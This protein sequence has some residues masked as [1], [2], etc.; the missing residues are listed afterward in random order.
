M[1]RSLVH[2]L[3]GFVRPLVRGGHV[4]VGAPI[5][6][7]ELLEFERQMAEASESVLAVDDARIAA[8]ASLVVRAPPLVVDQDDLCLAAALHNLLFL[9]HPAIDSWMVMGRRI[10]RVREAARRFASRPPADDAYRLLARHSLLHNL[11]RL[12]RSDVMISWWTGS[13][14]YYGQ[15]PPARLRRWRGLRRVHED[16]TVARYQDLLGDP[17]VEPVIAQL[18]RLSP[19]TDL[20]SQ[21]RKGPPLDWAHAVSVL[22]YPELAR[23]VAYHAISEVG[24]GARLSAAARYAAA[25]ERFV[26]RQPAADDVRAV[27]AFLVHLNALIAVG[28]AR[29]RDVDEPSPLLTTLLAPERAGRRLRGLSTLFALPDVLAKVDSRLAAPP[30]IF[31][32]PPLAKRWARHREQAREGVSEAVMDNLAGRLRKVLA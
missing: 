26:D 28:E 21:P 17:D 5:R 12:S 23:A 19:L 32:D 27:A 7:E 30:G 2:F 16:V 11:F 1:A 31:E 25:F 14:T 6:Q 22:R 3:D 4:H 20:L 18:L 24:P 15:Q 9:E 29:G 13:A 10:D 8:V